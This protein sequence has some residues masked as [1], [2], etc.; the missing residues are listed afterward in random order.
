MKAAGVRLVCYA[1]AVVGGRPWASAFMDDGDWIN[2][3]IGDPEAAMEAVHEWIAKERGRRGLGLEGAACSGTQGT[4]A[5]SS[6]LESA[7]SGS[8]RTCDV[9]HGVV[10]Y[11]EYGVELASALALVRAIFHLCFLYFF[12]H[13]TRDK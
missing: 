3:P 2:G 9:F 6:D 8:V 12:T 7:S 11:D 10:C 1:P 5:R 13:N 4:A